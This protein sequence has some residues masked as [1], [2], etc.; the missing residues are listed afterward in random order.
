M[1]DNIEKFQ[2]TILQHGP[3]NSR[4]YLMKLYEADTSDIIQAMDEMAQEKGYGKILAKVPGALSSIFEKC[5]YLEEATIPG[6]SRGDG[7]IVFMGK[8]F[9]PERR[10]EKYRDQIKKILAMARNK[11]TGDIRNN[12]E[13]KDMIRRCNPSDA[14]EMSSVY[15]QVFKTYPFPIHDPGYLIDTMRRHIHYFCVREGKA[16]IALAS[17]EMDVDSLSAEMMDFA[18]LPDW[19]RQGLACRLLSQM[20]REM[21]QLGMLT[22]YTIARALSP[23]MNITFSKMGYLYAGTLKNNSNISGRIESMNVWYKNLENSVA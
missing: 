11:T 5:G 16:V 4:I 13:D 21:K 2:R 8:Y 7:D 20:E 3:H 9:S 22:A 12:C 18:T 1:Y 23:G 15:Q 14:R 19:R 6:F 17:S 10:L